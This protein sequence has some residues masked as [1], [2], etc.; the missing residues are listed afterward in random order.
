MPSPSPPG[1][2]PRPKPRRIS[3]IKWNNPLARGLVDAFPFNEGGGT[4]VRNFVTG[5]QQSAVAA[6]WG[7]GPFGPSYVGAVTSAL[8]NGPF[9]FL[10]VGAGQLGIVGATS[11]YFRTPSH[12]FTD[13]PY[14][15]G[16]SAM[17][18]EISSTLF[19][20]SVKSWSY[21][22]QPVVAFA[23]NSLDAWVNGFPIGFFTPPTTPTGAWTVTYTGTGGF[24]T[25]NRVLSAGELRDI[26][27][28]PWQVF[29]QSP[30]IWS[31][32]N[33]LLVQDMKATLGNAT[34]AAAGVPTVVSHEGLDPRLWAMDGVALP[35]SISVSR[36]QALAFLGARP[37]NMVT[38]AA[39]LVGID[40]PTDTGTLAKTTGA[41]TLAAVGRSDLSGTVAA[42]TVA[43]TLVSAGTSVVSGAVASSTG[44]A[45]LA[46]GDTSTSDSGTLAVITGATTLVAAGSMAVTGAVGMATAQDALSANG[47]SGVSG[48]L[49]KS[50][51]GT[52]G[53]ATGSPVVAGD[54]VCYGAAASLAATG[55]VGVSGAVASSTGAA[56]LVVISP[57]LLIPGS[58]SSSL[59]AALL[60]S[61]G[62][63]SITGAM[64]ATA[65]AFLSS[66]GKATTFGALTASTSAAILTSY[67]D[68]TPDVRSVTLPD[69]GERVAENDDDTYSSSPSV[70]ATATVANVPTIAYSAFV[71]T[72]SFTSPNQDTSS[73]YTATTATI[74]AV[75]TS[76]EESNG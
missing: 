14:T 42:T 38:G 12:A 52:T 15:S 41:A 30:R 43:A 72:T 36:E 5:T 28:N 17:Q 53:A 23:G 21:P 6:S 46:A 40:I 25:W 20:G 76:S 45:T 47:V 56:T 26:S 22:L 57:P 27:R 48:A 65:A 3:G 29:K 19:S 61:A 8:V 71:Q 18:A 31:G 39:T 9:T 1:G 58:V 32:P 24:L 51:G 67:P 63:P 37:V 68:P 69:S 62:S 66:T 35:A 75:P 70:E 60:T 16:Q 10:T 55:S 44:A 50:T 59:G 74:I 33:H 4:L 34:L 49:A 54:I 11:M 13:A 2:A 64:A 73:P 7:L